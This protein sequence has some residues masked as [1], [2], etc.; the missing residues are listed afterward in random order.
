MVWDDVPTMRSATA[1]RE[2]RR[3]HMDLLRWSLCLRRIE[4]SIE[5]QLIRVDWSFVT[6]ISFAWASGT[7]KL[8]SSNGKRHSALFKSHF[9]EKGGRPFFSFRT[10]G[11]RWVGPVVHLPLVSALVITTAENSL[12]IQ[13]DIRVAFPQRNQNPR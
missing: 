6:S 7:S 8:P 10:E 3:G 9:V 13:N 4:K 1:F 5:S 11:H 12:Q 2:C